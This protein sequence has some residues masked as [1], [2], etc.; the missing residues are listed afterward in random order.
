MTRYRWVSRPLPGALETDEWVPVREVDLVPR[1]PQDALE[2]VVFL[3]PNRDAAEKG[4]K[5][6]ASGFMVAGGFVHGF[7][8]H[9]YVV[10]NRHCIEGK[11]K[12]TVRATEQT[13]EGPKVVFEDITEGRWW[14]HDD[15]DVAVCLWDEGAE[16]IAAH[17]SNTLLTRYEL[18]HLQIGPGEDVYLVAR[19]IHQDGGK[20]NHP[21]VHGGMVAK[22]PLDKIGR[23][24]CRGR[25]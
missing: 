22:L 5:G 13:T 8:H 1:V 14:K 15:Y 7:G 20:E 9:K 23:A 16:E 12:M 11:G 19:F 2:T 21:I 4:F 24:S 25:E 6:G 10:T 17:E 18:E 3:Y